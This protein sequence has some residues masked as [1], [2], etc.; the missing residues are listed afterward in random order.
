[1]DNVNKN[2]H[3]EGDKNGFNS[4]MAVDKFRL[5]VKNMDRNDSK[6]NLDELQ[7]KFIKKEAVLKGQSFFMGLFL[8]I[9]SE[10]CI[11]KSLY[12][13]TVAALFFSNINS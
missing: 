9:E 4:K 7:N 10:L 3:I 12:S 2:V 13:L 8:D 11:R 5:S 1:M 6:I